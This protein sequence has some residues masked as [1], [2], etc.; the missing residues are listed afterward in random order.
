MLS[1]KTEDELEA[2]VISRL[3]SVVVVMVG[4]GFFIFFFPSFH[5]TMVSFG[6]SLSLFFLPI[7]G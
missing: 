5:Y 6:A 7:S 3:I 4:Q 1:P 2:K